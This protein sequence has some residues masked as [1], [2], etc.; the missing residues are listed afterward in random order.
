VTGAPGA[1][2]ERGRP[3]VLGVKGELGPPG[4]PGSGTG[5]G[6]VGGVTYVRWGRTTCP[7]VDGTELVYA[8]RAAGSHWDS[9]G[10]T[11]DILC[12]PH[13][14]EYGEKYQPRA[15]HYAALHGVEYETFSDSPLEDARDQNV[16]CAVC[17]V[18]GRDSLLMIPAN[19]NCPATWTAEYD[20]Y[21]VTGYGDGG[22]RQTA[23]CVDRD[24]QYL[25]GEARNTN[26]ALFYHMEATCNGIECPPYDPQKELTCVV[27]TK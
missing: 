1:P 22:G 21:L 3:G 25:R 24:P 12:L 5:S 18:T 11:S 23:E 27:C 19:R 13:R 20:G 26:G 4:P 14:P 2:G 16:P 8:G 7:G 17:Y 10:G 15:Q 9:S 6:S